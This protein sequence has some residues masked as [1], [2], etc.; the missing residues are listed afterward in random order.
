MERSL[1]EY[2]SQAPIWL[3]RL[4]GEIVYW[5]QGAQELY[6]YAPGEAVGRISHELLQTK[7]PEPLAT[8]DHE[9]VETGD[10]RGRLEHRTKDGR[11]IWT[12]SLWRLRD[13]PPSIVVEQNTDV[14]KRVLLERQ[15]DLL[16]AELNHRVKNTLS[17]VQGL[18]RLSFPKTDGAHVRS[19]DGRLLA[20]SEA[21]NLLLR[22]HWDHTLLHDVIGIIA[23]SLDMEDRI[24]TQGPQVMLDPNATV[25]Y[26]L[27]L[28]ELSTNAL[29][30]GSL[31]A[32]AGRVDIRWRLDGENDERIHLVW[33]EVDG[34]KLSLPVS[35]G[36]GAR[37]IRR[38]LASELGTPVEM[39]FEECGLTCEF[40]GLVQKR[41]RFPAEAAGE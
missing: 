15:R 7:F 32:P 39:R 5:T 27:A 37:L 22:N 40:G 20:L 21:H 35:E 18:A 34:P 12:E 33:R 2:L 14:T 10:W 36:F 9:L 23:R 11:T 41:A 31:R 8:I 3:R 28:H 1:A 17:I 13:R 38:A 30:H 26:A 29:Q 25:A 24:A 6:G 4:D 19:F 16:V